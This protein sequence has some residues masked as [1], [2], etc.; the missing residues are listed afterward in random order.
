MRKFALTAIAT[1]LPLSAYAA[2]AA[3]PVQRI[4][5]LAKGRW[6]TT[7]NNNTPD[8]FDQLDRDFSQSFAKVY[9]EATKYPAI[10]GSDSPFDYDVIT[11]SQDGCPL[12]DIKVES[13]GAKGDMTVVDASFRLMDCADD[14]ASKAKVSELKFDVVTEK[15]KPVINDV[16]RKGDNGKWDSLVTEMKEDIK[17]GKALQ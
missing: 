9:R 15:G 17:A 12:K 14:A 16:H 13:E 4:I 6:E 11:S 2:S 5:D 7:E 3:D 1:L 10:D 8:Y